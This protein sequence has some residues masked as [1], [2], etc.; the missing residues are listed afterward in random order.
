[1]Y[2]DK[3]IGIWGLGKVGHSTAEFFNAQGAIIIGM[4]QKRI[5]HPPINTFYTEDEKESF[6]NRADYII[7]SPGIDIRPYYQQYKTKWITELD[8]FHY[9]WKKPIVAITG[10]VGKT[11]VT[12]LLGQLLSTYKLRVAVCGNIGTPMLDMVSSIDIY[13]IAVIEVSSFQ[14]E[15]C[16]SFAPEIALWT[17][18]APNHLDRHTLAEYFFAKAKI[19]TFQKRNQKT[20]IPYQIYQNLKDLM[21]EKRFDIMCQTKLPND[22]RDEL[23][24]NGNTLYT[25]NTDYIVKENGS[26][27][28]NILKISFLTPITFRENWL[29]IIAAIDAMGYSFEKLEEHAQSLTLPAHRMEKITVGQITFYNDSKSTTTASTLAAI[30]QLQGKNLTVFLGGLSKGVDRTNLIAQ[31]KGKVKKIVCFGKEQNALVE[32][33]L[34]YNIAATGHDTLDAAFAT[35]IKNVDPQETILLSPSGSSY[36][37]FKDYEERGNHFKTL[38]SVFA[39]TYCNSICR[40]DNLQSNI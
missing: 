3:I 25:L 35:V 30:E 20:I 27:Y 10:S 14:L 29:S 39:S 18:F 1:M 17:N 13:D 36:D 5:A 38:I 12:H 26:E 24:A 33:C 7:S 23:L 4:D 28:T 16:T 6:F 21:P 31:L 15:Y 19:C 11:T 22:T 8:L 9:H 40:D 34:K 32:M 37:L 2:K